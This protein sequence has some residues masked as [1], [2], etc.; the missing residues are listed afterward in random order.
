MS[1]MA[2]MSVYDITPLKIFFQGIS[3]PI[4]TKFGM[5]HRRLK[6]IIF[7][8]NVKREL[9]LNIFTAWSNLQL[10]LLYGNM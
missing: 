5:K 8:L 6:L 9:T 3:G 7:C 4:L 10:R 2:A 1:N